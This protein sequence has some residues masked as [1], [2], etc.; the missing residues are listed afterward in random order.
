MARLSPARRVAL[1]LAGECRQRHAR[2][3]DLMRT[4]A[5]MDGLAPRDRALATRLVLGTQRARGLLDATI[6]SHLTRGHLEPRL[7]DALRISTFEVLYLQTPT[8]AAVS[9]GVELAGLASRRARGLANAVLRRIA[10]E[11]L[12]RMDAARARLRD[13]GEKNAAPSAE[14]VALVAALP[15]WLARALVESLETGARGLAL[16][17]MEPP[18]P[19]VAANLNLAT[20]DDARALLQEAGLEPTPLPWPGCLA[21]G[22]QAGLAAS[23]LVESARVLPADPAAQVVSW[24]AAPAADVDSMLEVGQGRA[25]KTLLMAGANAALGGNVSLTS[26]DSVEFKAKLARE[27]TRT[28]GLADRAQTV[29]LDGTRL[30]SPD[31][32]EPLRRSF[33]HVFVDA[34]CSGTGTMRRHPEVAWSLECASVQ[35]PEAALPS[36]QLR[37]LAAAST[38]VAP[39]GTL[40]YSTCSDLRAE[41]EDVVHAFLASDAGRGFAPVPVTQA[42]CVASLPDGARAV[43]RGMTDAGGFLRTEGASALGLDCDGH[44]MA[45][46]RRVR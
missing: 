24:L 26:V 39:G 36:L 29:V 7:R 14:D 10:A 45:L 42:P 23:G 17:A 18:V 3:R 28:G 1:E 27:R 15:Q 11:D 6:E 30:G 34:P 13:Q 4:S 38:R 31:V 5:A 16:A 21:L 37:M 44:F 9:Q 8:R 33:P 43:L 46:M 41:D 35:G 40:A 22:R 20:A 12:P 2:A 32:P 25:T 19:T